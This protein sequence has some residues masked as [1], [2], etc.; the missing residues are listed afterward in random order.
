MILARIAIV[1]ATGIVVLAATQ[2]ATAH[3]SGCHRWHS[4][5]SDSGSYVCGDLGYSNYCPTKPKPATTRPSTSTPKVN[6]TPSR[7]S[8]TIP[9]SETLH[10]DSIRFAQ[11]KLIELGYNSGSIDGR[12]GPKTRNAVRTFQ[13][14]QNLPID[15]LLTTETLVSLA[16]A[17]RK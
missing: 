6:T 4:C 3:R 15:G 17:T 9:S 2:S 13:A 8:T 14:I 5:P 7:T 10:G 11:Q 1:V 12:M 16:R